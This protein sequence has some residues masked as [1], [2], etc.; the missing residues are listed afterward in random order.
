MEFGFLS[1]QYPSGTRQVHKGPRH[2]VR[3]K[4]DIHDGGHQQG[5]VMKE[6]FVP[7]AE[8]GEE[9]S[10]L[11]WRALIAQ[12]WH[13]DAATHE[14]CF[15]LGEFVRLLDEAWLQIQRLYPSQD[16][17]AIMPPLV[18]ILIPMLAKMESN[19]T[20]AYFSDGWLKTH[21]LE[22]YTRTKSL[23]NPRMVPLIW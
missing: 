3:A 6:L 14:L 7:L 12:N 1:L 8:N 22:M 4:D 17:K 20:V 5:Q 11:R 16:W 18:V 10:H 19:L 15:S 2:F 23:E 9:T 13:G 21:Q